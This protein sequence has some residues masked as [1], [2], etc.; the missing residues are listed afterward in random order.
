MQIKETSAFEFVGYE[1]YV[2]WVDCGEGAEEEDG[3]ED[4]L[5]G[6]CGMRF[7]CY[8][9]GGGGDGEGEVG[10]CGC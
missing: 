6:V 3:E 1:R 2:L 9:G 5:V 10:V 7:V 4:V 8:E